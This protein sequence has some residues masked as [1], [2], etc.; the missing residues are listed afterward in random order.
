MSYDH[1]L[2]L[3]S[4]LR[5]EMKN[6]TEVAQLVAKEALDKGT[7]DNVTCIIVYFTPP[8]PAPKKMMSTDQIDVYEFLHTEAERKKSAAQKV[9]KSRFD[10]IQPVFDLP[11]EEKL[12]EGICCL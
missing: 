9:E 4:K 11:T 8:K 3:A 12:L 10:A 1:A 2:A 6:P 7:L 5:S